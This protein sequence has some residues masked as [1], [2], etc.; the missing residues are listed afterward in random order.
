VRVLKEVNVKGHDWNDGLIESLWT[1]LMQ[2]S[3]EDDALS[4]RQFSHLRERVVSFNDHLYV[5]AAAEALR[6][7]HPTPLPTLQD[8]L[9]A[10]ALK[11]VEAWVDEESLDLKYGV[12]D[13]TA[14]IT[15]ASQG[16][17]AEVELYLDAGCRLDLCN[18]RGF[19]AIS[20]AACQGM[21]DCLAIL[22]NAGHER[23]DASGVR[24]LIE[25]KNNRGET[26]LLL[27]AMYGWTDCVKLLISE[28][29]LLL[30]LPCH[31]LSP[32]LPFPLPACSP[33]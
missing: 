6:E 17:D 13:D 8:E 24:D 2:D 11:V 7:S 22:L 12:D 20:A 27:A 15:A 10:A 25:H 5:G 21:D 31:F 26:P 29:L 4:R 28:G 1:A 32:S 9:K 33:P 23:L 30:A 14:L 3:C 18:K 19:S 16:D